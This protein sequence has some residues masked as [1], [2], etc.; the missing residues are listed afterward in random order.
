MIEIPQ[1]LKKLAKYPQN[2]KI[3]KITSKPKK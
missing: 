3:T 1:K 2:L